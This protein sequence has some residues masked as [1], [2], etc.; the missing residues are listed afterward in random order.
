MDTRSPSYEK[1]AA[2]SSQNTILNLLVVATIVTLIVTSSI[3]FTQSSNVQ[4][5]INTPRIY[6]S[7]YNNVTQH[8]VFATQQLVVYQYNNVLPSGI[9]NDGGLFTINTPGAYQ[10]MWNIDVGTPTQTI[11]ATFLAS[12]VDDTITSFSP[13]YT[14][15]RKAEIGSSNTAGSLLVDIPVPGQIGLFVYLS[16]SLDNNCD[17]GNTAISLVKINN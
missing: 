15:I 8:V 6:G 9:T 2:Q 7:F 3:L 11:I 17:L 5:Q 1:L 12:V 14:Q 13:A 16:E 10:V 4:T